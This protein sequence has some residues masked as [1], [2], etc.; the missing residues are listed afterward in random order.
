MPQSGGAEQRN[1]YAWDSA[2]QGL[3]KMSV[4]WDQIVVQAI[5]WGMVGSAVT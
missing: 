4:D 3:P 2:A 1:T 5:C